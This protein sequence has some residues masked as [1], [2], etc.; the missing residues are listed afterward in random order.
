M[1]NKILI[2]NRGEIA[3][4]IIRT[5]KGMGI[6]TV[7]I[8]STADRESQHVL[9]AD[10][11]YWVGESPALASYLN[12]EAIIAIA[13]KANVQ[14]IHPGYGFLSENPQFALACEKAGI[15]FIGPTIKALE[16]MASKQLAKQLLEGTAV[17]LTPGYH[18]DSQSDERLLDEAQRI[19]FPILLK[20]AAG[21]GGKGMRAVHELS[22][23]DSA[24]AG[25]RREAAASFADDTM[26]IEK[27]VL[28]PRHVEVQIMADQFGEAVH[29]FERD[30][31]IQ[32][33]H[34]KIIEEAPAPDLPGELRQGIAEAA[35]EVARSIGYLGAGTVEFLV[36]DGKHFY[37]MEM[38]T[39]LQVEHPV[40]EMITGLDLVAWQIKIAAGLPLPLKQ[41]GIQ[42]Q[43]HAIECRIYA[44]DPAQNFIPSIGKIS[45]LKEP[46]GE[47]VRIDTGVSCGSSISQYYDPMIAKLIVWGNNRPEA[48][49]RLQQAL[50]SYAV[51]GLKTNIGFLKAICN[52]PRFI[53]ADLGT[54]F[55]SR[56]TIEIQYPEEKQSLLFSA[57]YDYL[58]LTVQEQD[59]LFRENF[60]WQLHLQGFW[61]F[62]YQLEGKLHEI[63]I[64]PVNSQKFTA[65]IEGKQYTLS[66]SYEAGRLTIDDGQQRQSAWVI[67]RSD[68]I[69]IYQ[70]DGNALVERFSWETNHAESGSQSGRLTA[71]MPATVVAILKNE[72]DMVK[73]GEQLLILE[74]MKMEHS[75]RAPKDGVISEFFYNI[76]SQVNEGEELLKLT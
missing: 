46:S 42:A 23:F 12:I 73:K 72:G 28:N 16:A 75:I 26:I 5:A 14:A 74:A 35:C 71:P 8:Y 44:E 15:V 61:F 37:F 66:A 53:S 10:E 7:A 65:E 45:F 31:S 18:G 1:F 38:N 33:R 70:A 2:A 49:Q 3:C 76:G 43:G 11:A 50:N 54:D 9:Q 57:S 19:G 51:G 67:N 68:C 32:R 58:Q 25:A 60:S 6:S 24:L 56:E 55:L 64:I 47:G 69:E 4:R 34:Q 48:I 41:E 13:R 27:L 17:P 29:L 39:R 40:T 21:G 22:E 52:H 63:K 30:C 36:E 59:P 20:A 62:R